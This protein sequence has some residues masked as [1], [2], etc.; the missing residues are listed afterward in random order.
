[1]C[2]ENRKKKKLTEMRSFTVY[3]GWG[4]ILIFRVT[5]TGISRTKY[6]VI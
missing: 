3:P 2:S 5:V 6:L 1:M 4:L